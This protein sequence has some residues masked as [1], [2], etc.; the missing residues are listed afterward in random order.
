MRASKA[1][2]TLELDIRQAIADGA[3]ELHYQPSLHLGSNEIAGCEALLR[4]N[5][6]ARGMISPPSSFRSRK[7]PA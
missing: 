2:R 1:R 6:P 3:F 4:W 7:R 5:H